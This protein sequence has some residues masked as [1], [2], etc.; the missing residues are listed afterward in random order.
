M[1]RTGSLDAAL[2]EERYELAAL[3]LALGLLDAIERGA[4]RTRDDLLSL[5]SAPP[6]D[7]T[8]TAQPPTTGKP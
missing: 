8:Q 7:A 1:S 4:P 6:P 3:R 5:L 2:R